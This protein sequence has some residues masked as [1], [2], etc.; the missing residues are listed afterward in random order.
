MDLENINITV[1]T[2]EQFKGALSLQLPKLIKEYSD[3][4]NGEITIKIGEGDFFFDESCINLQ[5]LQKEKLSIKIIGEGDKTRIFAKGRVLKND[6]EIENFNINTG[7]VTLEKAKEKKLGFF[8]RLFKKILRF[9]GKKEKKKEVIDFPS[10]FGR[11]FYFADKPIEVIDEELKL[12][13]L[14]YK[15]L[16]NIFEV[17]PGIN[18]KYHYI[19]ICQWF[20]SNV[21][22]ITSANLDEGFVVFKCND[23]TYNTSKQDWSVNGHYFFSKKTIMPAF[24]LSSSDMPDVISVNPYVLLPEGVESVYSC[25]NTC[26][27]KIKNCAFRGFTISGLTFMGNKD[28]LN[29]SLIN[30]EKTTFSN[31]LSLIQNTFNNIHSD[32]IKTLRVVNTEITSNTFYKC[33]RYG[34]YLVENSHD[35]VSYNH[36]N[37]CGLAST[38]THCIRVDSD[39]FIV[40]HNDLY[41]YGSTGI[42]VGTWWA[43]DDNVKTYGK[44]TSNVLR[45]SKGY[46][47]SLMDSG[48]IYVCTQNKKVIISENIIDNYTGL[49]E[50]R[51]IFCDDGAFGFELRDNIITN[52]PNSFSIDSW[53]AKYVETSPQTKLKEPANTRNIISHN[54]IDGPIRYEGNE[55]YMSP[56]KACV[57]E[58]NY[59]KKKRSNNNPDIINNVIKNINSAE[60]VEDGEVFIEED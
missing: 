12:C 1:L 19:Q 42:T 10:Y 8:A 23:L 36:F 57:L 30:I 11:D 49:M 32:V 44:V 5:D 34:I 9:F 24:R 54:H 14:Y 52:I 51:G 35:L 58:I 53:R 20:K 37:D 18:D 48:A 56:E 33:W 50:N 31:K 15:K 29:E 27:L 4:K 28:K 38:N 3:D 41:N 25:E 2:Q 16:G 59:R 6:D 55:S 40:S 47:I 43:S 21:Y 45:N 46:K 22:E 13:K 60:S 17:N 26:F 7:F 39:D